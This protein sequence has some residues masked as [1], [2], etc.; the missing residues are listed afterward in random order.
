MRFLFELAEYAIFPPPWLLFVKL[1][2]SLNFKESY[3]D[4]YYNLLEVNCRIVTGSII[5]LNNWFS[6]SDVC[7]ISTGW[8]ELS[9]YVMIYIMIS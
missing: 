8:I 7:N 1:T 9:P 2:K 5:F 4:E 6:G 3:N